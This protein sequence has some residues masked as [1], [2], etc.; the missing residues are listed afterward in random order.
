MCAV[1]SG[2]AAPGC[3]PGTTA[4]S[5]RCGAVLSPGPFDWRPRLSSSRSTSTCPPEE[6]EAGLTLMSTRW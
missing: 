6:P 2:D 1:G 3:I 4:S 5:R